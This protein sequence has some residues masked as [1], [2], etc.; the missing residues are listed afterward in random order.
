MLTAAFVAL[1]ALMN[2]NLFAQTKEEAGK[3]FNATLKLDSTDHAGALKKMVEV[4][5][6][7]EK[8]GADADDIKKVA[9]KAVVNWQSNIA[10]DFVKD[11]KY[12]EAIAAYE[13]T[14]VYATKYNDFDKKEKTQNQLLKLYALKG[15]EQ[16]KADSADAAIVSFDKAISLDPTY[17]K[18]YFSKALA[19]KKKNDFENMQKAMDMTIELATKENDTSTVSKAKESVAG[20]LMVRANKA[21]TSKNY[22]QAIELANSSLTYNATKSSTY[23]ILSLSYNATSKFDPALESAQKGLALEAKP[24]K[25]V[26]FYFQIAKAYEGKKDI[27]NACENYKKVTSGAN[28]AAANYQ[29]ATVLKCK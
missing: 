1:L 28:K 17:T 12:N 5:G 9:T 20:S 13:Q 14:I 22:A 16:L 15:Q 8:I 7:C 19:Y 27:S 4:V 26:D 11:K 23:L 10:V 18:A 24:E 25:Q 3:V 2:T 29:M 6:M 21:M